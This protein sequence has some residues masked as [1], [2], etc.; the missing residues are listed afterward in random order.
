MSLRKWHIPSDNTNKFGARRA[1]VGGIRFH[2]RA[3][4]RRYQELCLLREAGE[5]RDLQL[6]K[7]YPLVVEG[8]KISV[9]ISDF[10]YRDKDG[11]A[12]TEDTKGCRT[13][14]YIMKKRLM[15]ALYHIDILETGEKR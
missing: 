13:Q 2:S 1:E 8:V 9:Y 11:N 3:E 14:V 15:K 12:V 10:D 6:Q 4:A 5:I 7:R